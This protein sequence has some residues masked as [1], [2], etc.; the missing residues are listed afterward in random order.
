M[1]GDELFVVDVDL[2]LDVSGE[3]DLQS[4]EVGVLKVEVDLGQALV[5]LGLKNE[6][7]V[8]GDGSGSNHR[9]PEE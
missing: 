9:G 7:E 2:L 4:I 1:I 5:A 8:V 6:M 3:V